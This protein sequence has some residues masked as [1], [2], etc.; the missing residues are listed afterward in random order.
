MDRGC[1]V[2]KIRVIPRSRGGCVRGHHL[3]CGGLVEHL[4]PETKTYKLGF[5]VP[6][7]KCTPPI[8][9]KVLAAGEP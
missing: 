4:Q 2:N 1:S 9:D 7:I 8:E 6:C 3:Y 5:G